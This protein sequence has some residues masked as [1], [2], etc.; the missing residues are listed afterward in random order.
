MPGKQET[1]RGPAAR[2]VHLKVD[3]KEVALNGFVRDVFQE[4]VVGLVRTLGTDDEEARIEL[5]IEPAEETF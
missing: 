4:T 1:E 2:E 3:G 5:T